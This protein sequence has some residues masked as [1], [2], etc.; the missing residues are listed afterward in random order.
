M[1]FSFMVELLNLRFRK[2]TVEAVELRSPTL[3]EEK[4]GSKHG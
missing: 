3:E 2:K 1:A 4:H